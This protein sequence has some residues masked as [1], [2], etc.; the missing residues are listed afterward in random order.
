MKKWSNLRN[1]ESGYYKLSTMVLAIS[2]AGMLLWQGVFAML[3]AEAFRADVGDGL[4]EQRQAAWRNAVRNP[5]TE[6]GVWNAFWAE[7]PFGAA[8]TGAG[9]TASAVPAIP[10]VGETFV[11]NYIPWRVLYR[12]ADAALI[13]TEYVYGVGTPYHSA[14]T[15]TPLSGSTLRLNL[16]YW[17][18]NHLG[19]LRQRALTP[20]GVDSGGNIIATPGVPTTSNTAVFILS[21][22]EI[23]QY[24]ENTDALISGTTGGSPTS[25]WLR[26]STGTG[27]ARSSLYG[28]R[29]SFFSANRD[30]TRIVGFRPALWISI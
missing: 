9:G 2:L 22:A 19:G 4:Q 18:A 27:S 14:N 13:I 10:A 29:G 6:G 26:W 5:A 24:F 16:N 15:Q 1:T 12:Q 17:A 21:E 25:W 20:N 3:G 30:T 11:Y 28:G 8:H 7:A 23:H